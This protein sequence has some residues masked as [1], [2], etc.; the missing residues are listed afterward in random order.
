MQLCESCLDLKGQPSVVDMRSGVAL[1]GVTP[2]CGMP[3]VEHNRCAACGT[4]F[5]RVRLDELCY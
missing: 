5:S 3:A 1:L 2:L 4:S